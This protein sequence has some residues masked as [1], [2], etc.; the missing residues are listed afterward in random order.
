MT[1]NK[2]QICSGIKARKVTL[3]NDNEDDE[4]NFRDRE[5]NSLV[6]F[7]RGIRD[8][9]EDLRKIKKCDVEEAVYDRIGKCEVYEE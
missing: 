1:N 7:C 3:G 8:L 2:L 9:D 6:M 5:D 4:V